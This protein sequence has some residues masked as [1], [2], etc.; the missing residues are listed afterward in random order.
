MERYRSNY[1]AVTPLPET[2][3]PY[4]TH[5]TDITPLMETSVGL[6]G[7]RAGLGHLRV[8]T[9]VAHA[10]PEKTLNG[11]RKILYESIASKVHQSGSTNPVAKWLVEYLQQ[12]E[13]LQQFAAWPIHSAVSRHDTVPVMEAA[14][15]FVE[16]SQHKN[17]YHVAFHPHPAYVLSQ[18]DHL[19][20]LN[21]RFQKDNKVITVLTDHLHL[22][23]QF[24]VYLLNTDMLI[25]PDQGSKDLAEEQLQIWAKR[26][27]RRQNYEAKI[28]E[29]TVI[30][31]PLDLHLLEPLPEKL[32]GYRVDQLNPDKD[33]QMKVL[34]P[35]GGSFPQKELIERISSSLIHD[36]QAAQVRLIAKHSEAMADYL[37]SFE[38][39]G[40]EVKTAEADGEV[41]RL[42]NEGFRTFVPS[43]VIT[44]PSEI[45]ANTY[46]N[47]QLSGGAI[48]L[49]TEPVGD[50][51]VQNLDYLMQ[52]G[53]IPT[54]KQSRE[55]TRALRA[56]DIDVIRH[57]VDMATS[58][59]GL[60]LPQDPEAA[61]AFIVTAKSMGIFEAMM[62]YETPPYLS[63]ELATD[64]AA[65]MWQTVADFHQRNR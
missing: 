62:H 41:I 58:W 15:A 54:D 48:Y 5:D 52:Q 56:H 43:L 60:R 10:Y 29:V 65:Q 13:S 3:F 42:Y 9:A 34:I 21:E 40:G 18:K 33:L 25:V 46:I 2:N 47:P 22:R 32:F 57:Y 44:K 11:H 30:P 26:M 20:Y 6:F 55:L 19:P 23:P 39:M 8:M 37:R 63:P 27:K 64:G 12:H 7:T 24:T 35:A 59:R 17:I 31:Y 49:F 4:A 53:L 14:S 61:A 38:L 16:Q 45:H 28:P 51:E 36:Y 50:Q 1:T